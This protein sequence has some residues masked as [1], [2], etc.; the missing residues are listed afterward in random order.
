MLYIAKPLSVGLD[1]PTHETTGGI[2]TRK[3]VPFTAGVCL[4]VNLALPCLFRVLRPA[5]PLAPGRCSRAPIKVAR[6]VRILSTAAIPSIP[7]NQDM[8]SAQR[9]DLS[10][11]CTHTQRKAHTPKDMRLSR[12]S[13]K[14]C[15]AT[16][17][18]GTCRPFAFPVR[19]YPDPQEQAP[20]KRA[21]A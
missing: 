3:P 5:R 12:N 18:Q 8:S 15:S 4:L 11:H 6:K 17:L 14:R 10:R 13:Q 16:F 7:P 1:T 19:G 20:S 2:R 21:T 9:K